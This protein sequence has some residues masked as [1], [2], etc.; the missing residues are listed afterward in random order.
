MDAHPRKTPNEYKCIRAWCNNYY[1]LW[2]LLTTILEVKFSITWERKK[3]MNK[4][5]KRKRKRKVTPE[6]GGY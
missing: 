6:F 1:S 3:K 5:V 2:A 4:G